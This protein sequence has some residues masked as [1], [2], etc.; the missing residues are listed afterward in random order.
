MIDD[1]LATRYAYPE[2]HV[3]VGIV[4]NQPPPA[5][6]RCLQAIIDAGFTTA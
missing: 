2:V 6:Y 1:L 4:Y 5:F 3:D